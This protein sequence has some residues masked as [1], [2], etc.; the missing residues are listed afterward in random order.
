MAFDAHE[1][2][3]DSVHEALYSGKNTVREVVLSF[4]ARIQALNPK[5]NAVL[6]L[7]SNA[8][9][10]ADELD[11]MLLRGQV[12]DLQLFGIP[13]LLKDNFNTHD[14]PTTGGSLALAKLQPTTDA[15]TVAALRKAGAIILGKANMHEMALEG[16][17]VSLLGGQT[18]NPYDLS[19][20]PGGSSGGSG[21]AVAASLAVFATGTDTMN[22][23]RSPASANRYVT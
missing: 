9:S 17:S 3:I 13:V 21:A 10:R 19:R 23:L 5:I 22:S 7:N 14:M 4:L 11:D 6:A 20:T 16:L 15:P 18:L 8:L 2:T 1:T 12:K